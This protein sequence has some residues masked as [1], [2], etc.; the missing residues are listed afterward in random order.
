MKERTN[1]LSGQ[2]SAVPSAR[3]AVGWSEWLDADGLLLRQI[4]VMHDCDKPL[5]TGPRHDKI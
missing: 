3:P 4:H 1:L 2:K 5:A